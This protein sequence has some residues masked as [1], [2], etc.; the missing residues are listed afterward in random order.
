LIGLQV[1]IHNGR[2]FAGLKI[3]PNIIGYKLD[4]RSY[5]KEQRVIENRKK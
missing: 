5:K 1:Q 3:T 4:L 2:G